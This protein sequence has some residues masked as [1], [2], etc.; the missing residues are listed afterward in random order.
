MVWTKQTKKKA[1]N[2]LLIR[3]VLRGEF[4]VRRVR[5]KKNGGGKNREIKREFPTIVLG[6]NSGDGLFGEKKAFFTPDFFLWTLV[7]ENG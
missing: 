6:P 1:V 7:T 2:I 3:Y 4:L 5:V